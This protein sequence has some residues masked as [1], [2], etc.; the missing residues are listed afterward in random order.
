MSSNYKIK[1]CLL[2]KYINDPKYMCFIGFFLFKILTAYPY[3]VL[4]GLKTLIFFIIMRKILGILYMKFIPIVLDLILKK[5]NISLKETYKKWVIIFLIL[6]VKYLIYYIGGMFALL[7]VL[8][9]DVSIFDC[10]PGTFDN[11]NK[12]KYITHINPEVISIP[13][14]TPSP[15][16]EIISIPSRTPSP[17]PGIIV[18]SSSDSS[19]DLF[20]RQSPQSNTIAQTQVRGNT[21]VTTVESQTRNNA[22]AIA[23]Q[24]QTRGLTTNPV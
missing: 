16:Q 1:K 13:S 5:L 3:E 10:L 9:F 15:R 6:L 4:I 11:I 14:R 17:R 20:V 23:T 12:V 2:L 18:S 8:I 19:N 24:N 21:S 7:Y 22:S